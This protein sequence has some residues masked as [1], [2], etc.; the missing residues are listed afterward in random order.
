M[1]VLGIVAGG[2]AMGW[3]A[4]QTSSLNVTAYAARQNDHAR[5]VDY[6]KRDVRRAISVQ[7]WSGAAQAAAG[8]AGTELRVTIPDYYADSREEDDPQG[9]RVPH[10]PLLSNGEVSY[11]TPLTVRYYVLNGAVIRSEN[12]VSRTITDAVGAFSLSFTRQ[13]DSTVRCRAFF[14]QPMKGVGSRIMR[15]EVD[16]T[17]LQ[18][19]AL[20]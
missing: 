13:V 11:G 9:S 6:L 3:I 19:N 8:A 4:I 14:N 2:V 5:V 15:R 10:T 20:Q 17:F 12:G 7:V 18:R 16:S 1:A